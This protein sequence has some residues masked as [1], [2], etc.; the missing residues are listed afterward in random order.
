M[1]KNQI[2]WRTGLIYLHHTLG[3]CR[4]LAES[5]TLCGGTGQIDKGVDR[6]YFNIP[7]EVVGLHSL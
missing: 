4:K 2:A 3:V 5:D 1:S 7:W 6:E